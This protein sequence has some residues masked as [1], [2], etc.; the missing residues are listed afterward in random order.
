MTSLHVD[1]SSI[2][3]NVSRNSTSFYAKEDDNES[4][5]QPKDDIKE[6]KDEL[7]I[8][9]KISNFTSFLENGLEDKALNSY[10]ELL[11]EMHNQGRF[12]NN[13]DSETAFKHTAQNLI[14]KYLSFEKGEEIHLQDYLKN[15]ATNP[16][17]KD[18]PFFSMVEEGNA[19]DNE[20][21]KE[22]P[23]TNI[24]NKLLEIFSR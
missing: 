18:N 5:F 4:L 17:D 2:M 15:Y 24:F 23:K 19:E 1:D 6:Q 14:E 7:A 8:H 12:E 11:E 22:V 16:I 9:I 20:K 13:E 3:R 21:G 10:Q